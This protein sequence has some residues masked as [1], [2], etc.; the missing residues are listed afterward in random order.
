MKLLGLLLLA[1]AL[2]ARADPICA[3][4][5]TPVAMSAVGCDGMAGGEDKHQHGQQQMAGSCSTCLIAQL[6]TP[7]RRAWLLRS[8]PLFEIQN[9]AQL[10]ERGAPPPTPPPRAG[11]SLGFSII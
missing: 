5:Q 4:S 10:H 1:L 2:F 6:N 7:L 9:E 8:K 3:T 11:S